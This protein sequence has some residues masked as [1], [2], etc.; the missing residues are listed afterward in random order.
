MTVWT[1][2]R[3]GAICWNSFF[4]SPWGVVWC[5]GNNKWRKNGV[6]TVTIVGTRHKGVIWKYCMEVV[7]EMQFDS[8]FKDK[9]MSQYRWQECTTLLLMAKL[10]CRSKSKSKSKKG[11]W[12]V[13]FGCSSVQTWSV[14]WREREKIQKQKTVFVVAKGVVGTQCC[15]TSSPWPNQ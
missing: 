2:W 8:R 6:D 10:K 12:Y 15:W 13:A 9:R 4:L 3:R 5:S 11:M 14:R 7:C 1:S